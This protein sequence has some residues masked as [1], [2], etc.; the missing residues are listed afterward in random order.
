[1]DFKNL[2]LE[3]EKTLSNCMRLTAMITISKYCIKP[4]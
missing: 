3:L 4:R 2:G 1:L